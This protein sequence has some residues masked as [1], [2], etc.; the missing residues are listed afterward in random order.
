MY[1]N[2]R[3]HESNS[4]YQKAI[5]HSFFSVDYWFKV[6][7]WNIVAREVKPQ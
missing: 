2:Q 5:K 3:I 4:T 6:Y 1:T 7:D